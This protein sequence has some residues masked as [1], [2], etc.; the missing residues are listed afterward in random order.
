MMVIS[1]EVLIYL[2]WKNTEK[3]QIKKLIQKKIKVGEQ[4]TQTPLMEE[5]SFRSI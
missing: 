5:N 2:R 3:A 1:N 4:Y